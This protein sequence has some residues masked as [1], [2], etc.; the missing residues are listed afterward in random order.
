[1]CKICR[2]ERL[3][4]LKDLWC[5]G[6]PLL[7]TIPNIE[8]LEVLWSFSCPSLM[9]MPSKFRNDDM[10][11]P[12]KECKYKI[13]KKMERMYNNIF[14]LWKRHQLNK[15]INYLE[16]L[17][18]NPRLPYMQYYIENNLY[19]ENVCDFKVGILNSKNELIWYKL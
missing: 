9:Y 15:Y 10:I 7:T 5:R 8:G 2:N 13:S 6:C 16:I 14:Y 11:L 17:Y 4:G 3:E 12:F 18:S 1:M 19:D